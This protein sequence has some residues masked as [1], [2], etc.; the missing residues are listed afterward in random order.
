MS[1]N[2][3]SE[4]RIRMAQILNLPLDHPLPAE[5]DALILIERNEGYLG[6]HREL[7]RMYQREAKRP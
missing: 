4:Q 6:L 3:L 1:I 5:V 2:T 7:W